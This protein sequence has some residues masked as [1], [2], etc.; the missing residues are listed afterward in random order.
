MAR[1]KKNRFHGL[2]GALTC[3]VS[4]GGSVAFET[5]NTRQT[6]PLSYQQCERFPAGNWLGQGSFA[7][8]Y[9]HAD[10]PTKVV[11][12]TGDARE[13]SVARRFLGKKLKGSVTIFDIAK[14]RGHTATVAVPTKDFSDFKD[15]TKQPVFALIT[16]RVSTRLSRPNANA[17]S[18]MWASMG[19]QR[20]DI[21]KVDPLQFQLADWVDFDDAVKKCAWNMGGASDAVSLCR[22]AMN[23]VFNA[24][25]EQA[26]NGVIPLDLHN[27]NWGQRPDGSPVI[28]DFGVSSAPGKTPRIDLAKAPKN[29]FRRKR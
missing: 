22:P 17:V 7:S 9:E 11:K 13:A 29:R 26:R 10:D 12:F 3:R 15:K 25:N 18:A 16:E 24:V 21:A 19:K 28:L 6:M 5:G 20:K 14:L 8:A 2:G 23:D 1:R 27:G 4:A